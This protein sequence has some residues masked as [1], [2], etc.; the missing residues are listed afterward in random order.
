MFRLIYAV[1][2]V[3]L[4]ST[5]VYGKYKYDNVALGN[6]AL[7]VGAWQTS[8]GGN[9]DNNKPSVTNLK[10]DLNF[11]DKKYINTL[12]ADFKNNIFW[13]PDIQ[14]NYFNLN[15]S[16]NAILAN[17]K[18]IN[19]TNIN[20]SVS[21]NIKYINIDAII[22]GYLYQGPFEFDLGLKVKKIDFTQTIVENSVDGDTIVTKGPSDIVFVPHIALKIDISSINT[23][24]KAQA[25]MFSIGDTEVK[26]YEYSFNY[27]IMR[28]I[29]L[30]YAYRYHSWKSVENSN[31][32][33]K[34]N[35]NLEGNYISAKILF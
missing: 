34:Y 9:I 22:Y 19:N 13:L 25:S 1:V 2:L 11:N 12:S 20:D 30:S 32:H 8:L 35:I 17:S 28:N 5:N 26:D 33:E 3:S 29:Y 7:S 10:S 23:V 27:R 14:I 21:T 16:S 18:T 6:I 31:I 15:Q 24:L 4:F